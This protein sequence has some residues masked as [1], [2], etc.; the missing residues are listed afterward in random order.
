M[1][2]FRE[3]Q[4]EQVLMREGEDSTELFYV[5]HGTFKVVKTIYGKKT[6]LAQIHPG[7]VV[8]EMSFLDK[9]PRSASV[10]SVDDSTVQVIKRKNYQKFL[11][12]LPPWFVILQKT[13]LDRLRDVNKKVVI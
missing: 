2:I 13:L 5:I 8:G 10:I 4:K 6:E 9:L 12:E 7:E 1:P 3:L 11:E